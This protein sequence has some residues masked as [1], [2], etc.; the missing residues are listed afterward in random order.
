M[1]YR[2]RQRTVFSPASQ[3]IVAI[4]PG[5]RRTDLQPATAGAEEICKKKDFKDDNFED[6]KLPALR[7]DA[8]LGFLLQPSDACRNL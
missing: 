4:W 3:G 5:G 8:T 2:F 1:P 7:V 6:G